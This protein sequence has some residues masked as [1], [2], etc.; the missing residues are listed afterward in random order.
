MWSYLLAVPLTAREERTYEHF[1]KVRRR[2]A[3][4]ARVADRPAP[5][6]RQAG[7]PL[8]HGRAA[9]DPGA[10]LQRRGKDQDAHARRC[11]SVG[12]GGRDRPLRGGT[13]PAGGESPVIEA[14]RT[15]LAATK[16]GRRR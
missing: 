9:C 12:G 15:R 10:V 2:A 16:A 8:R 14:L 1:E 3:C 11:G 5:A 7:L 6:V 13:G 4:A